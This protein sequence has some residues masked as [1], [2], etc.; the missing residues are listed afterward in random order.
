MNDKNI[1]E[2]SKMMFEKL[3]K[4]AKENSI[5]DIELY[6][7][8]YAEEEF[9]IRNHELDTFLF[10]ENIG[11]SIR[12]IKDGKV[13]NSYT[14]KID[15]S[16]DCINTLF[17]NAYESIVYATSEP[18]YNILASKKD[19]IDE[20]IIK[21]N[22][23]VME[24]DTNNLKKDALEI[25]QMLYDYDKRI[26]NVPYSI[27]AR[28]KSERSIINS[29]GICVSGGRALISYYSEIIAQENDLIKTAGNSFT[30][31]FYNKDFNATKFTKK[32]TDEAIS[33][34][35][36][37]S[38]KSGNYTTI[39]ENNAMRTLLGS[40]MS[41]FSSDNVQKQLSLFRGK[42]NENVAAENLTI[43]DNPNIYDGLGNSCFDSEGVATKPL[44]LIENG[45]LK[46]F[47]YNTYTAKKDN[48]ASTG[49]ASRSSYRGNISVG[50]HNV[51]LKE[52]TKSFLDLLLATNNGIMVTDLMGV[53]AGVN[54]LSGDFSLQ[55]EG[56][57]IK[58]G[59][60][61]DRLVPFV[62]SGNILDLFKKI[63]DV[64]NDTLYNVSSIYSPSVMVENL[65]Y[66]AD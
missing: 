51:I 13:G 44:T 38:F 63:V 17:Q 11:A 49:H 7:S 64:G 24:V 19:S 60:L 3:A 5:D 14:E 33:K 39:F 30:T 25:E 35:K 15:D 66:C 32:I 36:S 46:N 12:I 2:K 20:E 4:K 54:P 62:V 65:S 22:E 48:I 47:L 41:M 8:K 10:A 37:K 58:N 31:R 55:A 21:A 52:G 53:H 23:T 34:I 18:Q 26:I 9:R 45:I 29:S 61:T 6:M 40:Y 57:E 50:S 59:K 43:I 28:V 1:L 16:D 56:I 42:I 27:I